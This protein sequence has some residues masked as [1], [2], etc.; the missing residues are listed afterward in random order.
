VIVWPHNSVIAT[1]NGKQKMTIDQITIKLF[2]KKETCFRV[3]KDGELVKVC[4]TKAEAE[5]FING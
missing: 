1:H 2:G 4:A 3:F 5:A